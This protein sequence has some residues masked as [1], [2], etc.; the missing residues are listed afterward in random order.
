MRC[1]VKVVNMGASN[2]NYYEMDN[3]GSAKLIALWHLRKFGGVAIIKIAGKGRH[4]F[5]LGPNNKLVEVS[6]QSGQEH[7]DLIEENVDIRAFGSKEIEIVERFYSVPEEPAMILF[8][9][10]EEEG[11]KPGLWARIVKTVKSWI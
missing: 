10:E 7:V 2:G 3:V 5:V 1:Q 4:H 11:K 9:L 6:E 8:K